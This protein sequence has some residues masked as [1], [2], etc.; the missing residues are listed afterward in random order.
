MFQHL[1]EWS[2]VAVLAMLG[3]LAAVMWLAK[4]RPVTGP[5]NEEV[6]EGLPFGAA[7]AVTGH[8]GIAYVGGD[9][10]IVGMVHYRPDRKS[11][12]FDDIVRFDV[13]DYARWAKAH[14]YT[15]TKI[16]LH[17]IGYWFV[18]RIGGLTHYDPPVEG[19]RQG[20]VYGH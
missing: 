2:G 17:M 18:D 20:V 7:Y 10:Y 3:L 12:E 6:D 14:G 11:H 1:N 4:S 13:G 5:G 19:Y 16:D 9:G 15:A 8:D